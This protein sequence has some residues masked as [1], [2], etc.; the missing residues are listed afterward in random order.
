V[1]HVAIILQIYVNNAELAFQ[2][3][4]LTMALLLT[5]NNNKEIKCQKLIFFLIIYLALLLNVMLLN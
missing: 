3:K 2:F 1:C 4:Q 5:L